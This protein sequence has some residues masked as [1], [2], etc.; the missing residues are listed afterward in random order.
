ML[1]CLHLSDVYV[2]I[3]AF[4]HFLSPFHLKD[5]Q[6]SINLCRHTIFLCL[7][8]GTLE[9]N[10]PYQISVV[11]GGGTFWQVGGDKCKSK[12]LQKIFVV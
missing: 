11:M 9:K 5:L 8:N 6:F 1:H 12:K 3:T 10:E 2:Q 4:Y 7:K